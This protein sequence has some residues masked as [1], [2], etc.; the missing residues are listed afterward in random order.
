MNNRNFRNKKFVFIGDSIAQGFD[1]SQGTGTYGNLDE[2]GYAYSDY[3]IEL[4]QKNVG[5]NLDI[6]YS[7]LGLSASKISTWIN[8]VSGED[9]TDE[10]R[11]LMHIN[12][13]LAQKF[14]HTCFNYDF[15]SY[16]KEIK[17]A[18]YL[19][20]N[21]SGIEFL[22]SISYVDLVEVMSQ[23]DY[24][25]QNKQIDDLLKNVKRTTQQI[26]NEYIVLVNKIKEVNTNCKIYLVD[27]PI[28]SLPVLNK[29]IL[30]NKDNLLNKSYSIFK[31]IYK[32][33]Q[34]IFTE[35]SAA[36]NTK[37]VEI[38]DFEQ[39]LRNERKWYQLFL[40][41][42][43]SKKCYKYIGK[44]LYLNFAK[45]HRLN[46]FTWTKFRSIPIYPD[47]KIIDLV[48]TWYKE[49]GVLEGSLIRI[50]ISTI[51]NSLI[52]E[53]LTKG[54]D[55]TLNFSAILN[56]NVMSLIGKIFHDEN[57]LEYIENKFSS[58]KFTDTLIDFLANN[59]EFV[60]LID[61]VEKFFTRNKNISLNKFWQFF[62]V[63]NE[64]TLFD[65]TKKFFE[66][67]PNFKEEIIDLIHFMLGE[68][69]KRKFIKI[70]IDIRKIDYEF[71]LDFS[72]VKND[73]DEF[74]IIFKD[75]FLSSSHFVSFE[76]YF[77]SFIIQNKALIKQISSKF[78]NIVLEQLFTD[79]DKLIQF[80]LA[81]CKI[82]YKYLSRRDFE[83]LDRYVDKLLS[84]LNM[85]KMQNKIINETINFILKTPKMKLISSNNIMLIGL[86][87]KNQF[88][89]R[90]FL[91]LVRGN[92]VPT[93]NLGVRLAF[94]KVRSIFRWR[95]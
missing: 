20:I 74:M 50:Y 90:L 57:V 35:V 7:N 29:L 13:V 12:K 9:F 95:K 54:L 14:N 66:K 64:K 73:L 38:F 19:F 17:E 44:K 39:C 42:H 8:I 68:L 63:S 37:Y 91:S 93:I 6:K 81:Y 79:K 60:T 26:I 1:L 34:N 5:R 18:D 76:S 3:F 10:T 27:Y 11:E 62:L 72:L 25:L 28:A 2:L 49:L 82:D 59:Q 48:Q 58:L 75:Y 86:I 88:R 51:S 65:I 43:C 61:N 30:K 46:K 24:Y 36:T 67:Y 53:K 16:L 47:N 77:N 15:D 69:N 4:I 32:V 40:D 94:A 92:L 85:T 23:K 71:N 41:I 31:S 22:F 45:E 84:N 56:E 52:T 21:S 89:N 55:I 78:L 83:A 87:I 70:P 80:I 33:F